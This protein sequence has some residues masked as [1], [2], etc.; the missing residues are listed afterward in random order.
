[1]RS[2]PFSICCWLLLLSSLSVA[3]AAEVVMVRSLFSF[4]IVFST[5]GFAAEIVAGHNP[6]PRALAKTSSAVF[7]E[8]GETFAGLDLDLTQSPK[9][10]FFAGKQALGSDAEGATETAHV[11]NVVRYRLGLSYGLTRRLELAISA[12]GS[13]EKLVAQNATNNEFAGGAVILKAKLIDAGPVQI[14]AAP[15][16][17]TG[18]GEA[19]SSNDSW[20]PI[21]RI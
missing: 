2:A 19:A 18:A 3:A 1:M 6:D 15:F 8:R 14:A 17:E 7:M 5:P 9:S 4:L 11:D 10:S 13:Q 21:R 16:F 20:Q 12:I